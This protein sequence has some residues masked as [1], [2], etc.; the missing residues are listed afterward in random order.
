MVQ[1]GR[2]TPKKKQF[3]HEKGAP[4]FLH[5]IALFWLDFKGLGHP[6]GLKKREKTA[7]GKSCFFGLK[8]KVPKSVFYY[9]RVSFGVDFGAS[10]RP[11][12]T[13]LIFR[14]FLVSDALP[15]TISGPLLAPFWGHLGSLLRWFGRYFGDVSESWLEVDFL[16]FST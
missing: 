14:Y 5:T 7:P 15:W 16:V 13:E 10:G 6:G 1:G 2:Q 4:T 9:F 12:I 11:K 8:R 3:F